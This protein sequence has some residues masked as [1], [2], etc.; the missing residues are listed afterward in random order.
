MDIRRS[1][2]GHKRPAPVF[3]VP[4]PFRHRGYT[5]SK[6]EKQAVKYKYLAMSAWNSGNF[7]CSLFPAARWTGQGLPLSGVRAHM[8]GI[9]REHSNPALT[10]L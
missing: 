9:H 2:L 8:R 3:A 7:Q 5:L 4:V 10:D 1:P 6:T